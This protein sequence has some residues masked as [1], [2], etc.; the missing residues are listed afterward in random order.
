MLQH[1]LLII[2]RNFRRFKSSFLIN[3]IGLST[4]LTC[5]LLIYLW[6]H[7]EFHVDKFHKNDAR[8]YEV[9]ENQQ[10]SASDTRVTNSTP[11]LLAE[12]L[13]ADIPEVENAVVVTDWSDEFN[14][15]VDDK[16]TDAI[17]KY[18]GKDFFKLFTYPL[19]Q[20]DANKVLV[21]KNSIVISEE[22]A[23]NLFGT[24]DNVLGK[25]VMFQREKEFFVTGI[26]QNVPVNSSDK[27]D[28]I[29]SYELIKESTPGVLDWHNSGPMTFVLLKEGADVDQFSKKILNLIKTKTEDKHRTLVLQRYSDTYLYS[30]YSNGKWS[31]GRIEYV[32]LFSIIALFILA[33]ACINFMNLS[34]AKASRRIKEVGIKK[35]VGA[36]RRTLILQ[37]MGEA[38]LMSTISLLLAVLLVDILLPQFNLITGKQLALTLHGD[39]V[40]AC[41]TIALITGILAGSY[42]ALYLSG[43]SPAIV[44]KGKFSSSLGELWARKG[45]VVF[46]FV[47]SVIFIVSVLVVYK[48]IEYVQHKNLGYDKE[49]VIYFP[50]E[51]RVEKNRETFLTELRK[52]PGIVNASS[53]G[54]SMVG[55]GNTTDV[56]WE[57]KDPE[58][59]TPFAIRPVNYDI[60]EM[61]NIQI[62]DGRSFSRDRND[63]LKVIF[64]ETGI[65]AMNLKNPV[66]KTV[67]LGG[68]YILEII[69]VAKDFHFQSLRVPVKPMFFVLAPQF[70]SLIMARIEAGKETET[71]ERLS[72]FSKSYNPD[73]TFD[74]RFL[75]DDYDAQYR[76]EQ[77]ISILARYF[78]FL[79]ILISCLGLFGLAAF[80]AERRSKEIGI[81]KVLGSSEWGIIY[82]LS[83]DFT[84]IVLLSACIALPISYMIMVKWLDNFAY[85][86]PL[87]WWYFAG[88]GM[89]A[90]FIAWFTVGMQAYKASRI[91]PVKC[92]KE[93]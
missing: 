78:S 4:G 6:V 43:F 49:N 57:G 66:G 52:I 48:Q 35:A 91:N 41:I 15:S 31:G 3:L 9:F 14:L 60:L 28:F 42:P 7:D 67:D 50:I 27:F 56:S 53:I 22:T 5:T 92:L 8:L 59:R 39:L 79:A 83:A 45:L 63:S 90:L 81:R 58:D 44:L 11:G 89:M 32:I 88:S 73:F 25:T 86:I 33:I 34:T 54:Q 69:G 30:D 61:M 24:T 46:Q 75:D 37:Y 77:R 47:V 2:Y 10:N 93:E 74:Y 23:L 12:T 38:I 64:N 85:R 65:K 1:N 16:R 13:A 76:S 71:I 17:G 21:D 68:G 40:V 80:T 20:G 72:K 70:T 29:L 55:G 18:T 36:N 84:K 26:F 19:I 82:L 62:I 51:G 87:H